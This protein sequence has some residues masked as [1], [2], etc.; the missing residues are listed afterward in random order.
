MRCLENFC[1]A[2]NKMR[3]LIP[4]A[5]LL[6]IASVSAFAATPSASSELGGP[7]I[8]VGQATDLIIQIRDAGRAPAPSILAPDGLAVTLVHTQNQQQWIN[9]VG[10][11]TVTYVFQVAGLKPGH[12]TLG[13]WT[14]EGTNPPVQIP[15]Q[16]LTVM[17]PTSAVGA[18]TPGR[19]VFGPP[20]PSASKNSSPAHRAAQSANAPLFLELIAPSGPFYVGQQI[21]VTARLC[22]PVGAQVQLQSLPKLAG[23]DLALDGLS[24]K[25]QES[26]QERSGGTYQ[27]LSWPA[28]V[29][30]IKPS[31]P[32]LQ[33][34]VDCVV[35]RRRSRNLPGIFGSDPFFQQL[36]DAWE[37]TPLRVE[38]EMQ[39]WQILPLPA[40]GR[41]ADFSGAIG[42]F[43]L[44]ATV[45][46]DRTN[47]G[48]PVT[49]QTRIAGEG[50]FGQVQAPVLALPPGWKSYPSSQ[51]FKPANPAPSTAASS[52]VGIVGEKIFDQALVPLQSRVSALP[53]LQFSYFDPEAQ[54]YTTLKASL[55]PI[56]IAASADLANAPAVPEPAQGG[57]APAATSKSV[58]TLWV[59]RPDRDPIFSTLQPW[60]Y[61]PAF[62]PWTLGALILMLAAA[63]LGMWRRR[64]TQ[65]AVW[66]QR[67]R[68]QAALTQQR[69][70]AERALQENDAAAFFQA[71]RLALQE[72]LVAKFGF[73]T[74]ASLTWLEIQS[75]W[76][77]APVSLR[78]W[79]AK[80]D[81]VAYAG[82]SA[83][84]ESLAS[85][86]AELDEEL[87]RLSS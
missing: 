78:R 33:A 28:T 59:D 26:L 48:D 15:A 2:Y 27:V 45:Q 36:F 5:L 14:V 64:K 22:V 34:L 43:T 44:E 24:A 65:D 51:R 16:T 23:N 53:S 35:M 81:E 50:N 74:A 6:C 76:P 71:G 62:W 86:K 68:S 52:R 85:W 25:P 70:T 60:I 3:L 19:A 75:R 77:D 32:Q 12:Y 82:R 40:Q 61:R 11:S 79:L 38:S 54:H 55:P 7:S 41:P 66:Q 8:A 80:A 57:S 30:A 31:T 73:S 9:G 37:P 49:L 58:N 4:A 67:Q 47:V 21:P 20:P 46:P 56:A 10:S 83:A 87:A 39:S 69:S 1:N 13:P 84:S 29:T 17:D 18:N 72:A 63:V 42:K